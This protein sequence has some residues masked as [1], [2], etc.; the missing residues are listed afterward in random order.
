[1]PPDGASVIGTRF[2]VSLAKNY[3]INSKNTTTTTT[4]QEDKRVF[5][6]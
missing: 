6:S 3:F 1:V 2:A 5:A 4:V